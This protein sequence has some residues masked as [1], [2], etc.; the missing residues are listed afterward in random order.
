MATDTKAASGAQAAPEKM[1]WLYVFAIGLGFFTT[2]RECW[3]L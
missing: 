3:A 1:R 2:R